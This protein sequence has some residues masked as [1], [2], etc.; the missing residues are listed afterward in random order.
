MWESK[1]FTRRQT[2]ELLLTTTLFTTRLS[3]P[4]VGRYITTIR[5]PKQNRL[6]K[7][8]NHQINRHVMRSQILVVLASILLPMATAQAVPD[9]L[10]VPFTSTLPACASLCGKLFDVQGACVPTAAEVPKSCFCADPRLKP[11]LTGTAGV[12]SVCGTTSCQ[13]TA[14]LQKIQAWYESFCNIV[15]ANPT[16]TTSGTPGTTGSGIST[17]PRPTEYPTW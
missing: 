15:T 14:S 12:S 7:A 5:N 8:E 1:C 2:G 13:D 4:D 16:T 6:K 10:L 9:G 11:F 17:T 3:F